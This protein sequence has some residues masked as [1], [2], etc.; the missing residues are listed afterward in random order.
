MTEQPRAPA[1]KACARCGAAF[2]CGAE[3]GCWCEAVA[4][5]AEAA[6]ALR[7]TY[8][9]CLCPACLEAVAAQ[10]VAGG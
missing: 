6:E 7:K 1:P 5:P 3:A 10:G 2:G 9:D 4:L 8:D